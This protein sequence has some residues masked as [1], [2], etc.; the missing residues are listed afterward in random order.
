MFDGA[1]Q[2]SHL[3]DYWPTLVRRR[4][5]I[6]PCVAAGVL[7]A[8]IGSFLVTPMYRATATVQIERQN[9]NI[10]NVKDMNSVD[11]SWAAYADFYQTQYKILGSEAVAR[12][13]AE[14]LDLLNHPSFEAGQASG[15]WLSRLR[16]IIPRRSPS[17]DL[18]PT[19]AVTMQVR[20]GLLISPVRNSQLVE[21]SWSGPEPEM[22]AEIA[23]AV[24]DAFTHF[25]IESQFTASDQATEFLVDQTA[26]LTREI[27]AIE[28]RLQEYGEARRI[29][30]IDDSNNITLRALADVAQR[31]TEAQTSL[32]QAEAVYRALVEAEPSSL[33]QVLEN[34]LINQLKSE[35][36]AYEA[37][38]SQQARLFKED[39]PALRSLRSKLDQVSERLESETQRIAEGAV[40][41]AQSDLDRA[42][43]EYQNLDRLLGEQEDAAQRLRKDSIEFA[44]LQSEA[45]KKRETLDALIARQNE[46]ALSTR[47][48]DLDET[49]SNIRVVDRAKVPLAPFRPNT[50]FNLALGLVFGVGFGIGLAFLLDYV[51]NT[52]NEPSQLEALSTAP[53]LAIV[54][55]QAAE[56]NAG[57][58][59]QTQ[60]LDRIVMLDGRSRA[61]EAFREL[62]TAILLSS[63][64]QAPKQLAVTSAVP[65]EGKSS[66]A[67]N[68]AIVLAQLGRKVLLVDTD[69]R[70]PRL[71]RAFKM[72]NKRGVS[73]YLSG[74]EKDPVSLTHDGGVEGLR[75]LLSGPIPPNPSELLNSDVFKEMGEAFL[76]AGYDHIVYDTPPVL[77]VSDP[78]VVGAV[79]DVTILV[80]RA[81][82]TSRHSVRLALEKLEQSGHPPIGVVLNDVRA[83]GRV[84][85]GYYYG[86]YE[87][88]ENE[89]P[90]AED[91]RAHGA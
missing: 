74:L 19:E 70:K 3:L 22:T 29:V 73:T 67:M 6:F 1:L 46:M 18:D 21:V 50:R 13:A 79:T 47:L 37:E 8:L 20:G 83:T 57:K 55:R 58:E 89:R 86:T 33:P 12:R 61:A 4:W 30:S 72:P 31:R 14:R 16:S 69:L 35:H 66:V 39:W 10:L 7:L 23:N 40:L 48:K 81:Q 80:A 59:Q 41:A 27:S 76:E 42:R 68:L 56:A 88:P 63:A 49:S 53:L 52:I 64:G 78:L 17:R 84:Y 15:S 85:Q 60:G 65:E 71:D 28:E 2:R 54:P 9:P 91:K 44:N 62:R 11:Y 77:S 45:N 90:E 5:A 32:A 34:S 36:A 43:R 26:Q 38:L 82:S 87:T 51:D 24:V 25:N 75:I